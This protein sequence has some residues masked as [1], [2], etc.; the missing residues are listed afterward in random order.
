MNA[1]FRIKKWIEQGKPYDEGIAIYNEHGR[2]AVLKDLFKKFKS[3]FYHQKL[4]T[5]LVQIMNDLEVVADVTPKEI[6]SSIIAVENPTQQLLDLNYEKAKLFRSIL[7]TRQEIKKTIK[8]Q[9]VG[10]V[11]MW[12][13]CEMMK[14]KDKNGNL[15]PFSVTYM[16]YN[17]SRKTGGEV[18][19][20]PHCVLRIENNTGSKVM[21]GKQYY[22]GYQPRHWL[23]STRNFLPLG[24]SQNDIKKL[25]V[26]LMFEFNGMEVVVSEQG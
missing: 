2:N 3:S 14:E 25:H 4:C 13:A 24:M 7:K 16:S 5:E 18:L 15:K 8:L 20:F 17:A 21:K 11:G 22:K 26:W 12:D 10:K 9:T 1:H 6:Q 19:K 23:N